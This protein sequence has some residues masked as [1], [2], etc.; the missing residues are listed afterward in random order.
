MRVVSLLSA[1]VLSLGLLCAAAPAP[2]QSTLPSQ[3]HLLV[4]GQATRTV[5]PDRFGVQVDLVETG[6]DTDA[7]RRR[8]EANAR[9]VLEAFGRHHALADTVRA[10]NLQVQPETRYENGRQ[11]HLGSRVARTL[12]AQFG[13]VEDLQ[14]FLGVLPAGESVQLRTLGPQYA[15]WRRL[16]G[17]LKAEAAR[18]ARASAEG[19]AGA[20]GSRIT[21]LYTISDVAPNF[22]YGVHAGTWPAPGEEGDGRGASSPAV[23]APP[24]P[25][26]SFSGSR[27][28]GE[29]M[30]AAPI[31]FTENVYAIFLIGA[32]D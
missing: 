14:A 17:E 30:V 9:T 2:A 8:V 16:R 7:A 1:A 21:G 5:M 6:H 11:V 13:K 20:Y 25:P 22:A 23:P 29:A 27:A 32:K 24:P 28:A 18:Q 10:D 4:K 15:D 12:R 19:L 31:T 26:L 3:P